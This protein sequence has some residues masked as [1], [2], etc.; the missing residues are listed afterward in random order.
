MSIVRPA[1]NI[2]RGS[3]RNDLKK[4]VFIAAGLATIAAIS[5]KFFVNDWRKAKY[6]EFFRHLLNIINQGSLKV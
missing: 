6:Q 4:H 3:L 5:Y 2:M 1:A